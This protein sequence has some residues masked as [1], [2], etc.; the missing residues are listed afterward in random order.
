LV[1]FEKALMALNMTLNLEERPKILNRLCKICMAG[2]SRHEGHSSCE[3]DSD[4]CW[5][6]SVWF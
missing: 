6:E 5:W 1:P 4:P 3:M 2:E